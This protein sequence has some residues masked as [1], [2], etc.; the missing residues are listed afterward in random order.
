MVP[1]DQTLGYLMEDGSATIKHPEAFLWD[2]LDACDAAR[3]KF[4]KDDGE[5][6][7][8]NDEAEFR[9]RGDKW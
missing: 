3:E 2:N 6:E 9:A 5:I 1:L 4:A 8:I 7:V